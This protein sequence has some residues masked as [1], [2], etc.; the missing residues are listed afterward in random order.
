MGK[1]SGD[2]SPAWFSRR[3]N[4]WNFRPASW[5][6]WAVTALYGLLVYA[7]ARAFRA[8]HAVLFVIALLVLTVVLGVVAVATSRRR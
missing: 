7:A 6:G 3:R 1:E 5:Q 2:V 4:G 8:Q